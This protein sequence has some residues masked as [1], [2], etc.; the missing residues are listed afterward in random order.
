MCCEGPF[1]EPLCILS[2]W[3]IWYCFAK[4]FGDTLTAPFHRQLDLFLQGSVH[5]NKRRS[6]GR[7]A[8][9]QLGSAIFRPS[10]LRSFQPPCSFLPTTRVQLFK[11]GVSNSATQESIM[12]AHNKTH[13]T[14]VKI[15][16][17]LKDSSCYS[18]ISQNLMLTILASNASS[19][20]TKVFKC[21]HTR[22]DSIFTQWFIV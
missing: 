4:L 8:T 14:H 2:R 18:P 13:F 7:S 1:G 5:W 21:P 15:N 3:A 6:P 9:R 17:V 10:F 22:N 12:N 19:S 16:C 20:S 11:K